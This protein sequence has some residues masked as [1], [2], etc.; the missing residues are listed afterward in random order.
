MPP[1]REAG[2]RTEAEPRRGGAAHAWTSEVRLPHSEDDD[3]HEEEEEEVEE[4]EEEEEMDDFARELASYR[5]LRNLPPPAK[6]K[7]SARPKVSAS[8]SSSLAAKSSL[9]A[10]PPS[11]GASGEGDLRSRLGGVQKQTGDSEKRKFPSMRIE[12]F[13]DDDDE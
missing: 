8:K 12:V 2:L 5:S 9:A 11:S 3:D 6:T 7:L 10:Q 13:D 1:G 4:V